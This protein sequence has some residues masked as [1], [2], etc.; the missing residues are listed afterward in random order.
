MAPL[1][2]LYAW[3]VIGMDDTEIMLGMLMKILGSDTVA[4]GSRVTGQDQV[5]IENL[6]GGA[7]NLVVGAAAFE[8]LA[9]VRWAALAVAAGA[10]T[11][12]IGIGIVFHNVHVDR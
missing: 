1:A 8:V 11:F 4:G 12:W 5:F 2:S 6:L 10:A 9:F 3:R 7:A